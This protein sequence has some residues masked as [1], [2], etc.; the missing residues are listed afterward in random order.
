[1]IHQSLL[2]RFLQDAPEHF[3]PE[4]LEAAM[5]THVRGSGRAEEADEGAAEPSLQ[6]TMTKE[7]FDLSSSIWLETPG[8]GEHADAVEKR[9]RLEGLQG[10]RCPER[11]LQAAQAS[12]S[13]AATLAASRSH[14]RL[15]GVEKQ[16]QVRERQAVTADLLLNWLHGDRL[17]SQMNAKQHELLGLVVDRILIEHGLAQAEDTALRRSDPLVWLMHGGPGTGKTHVLPFLREL[18]GM[19]DY[20]Q[21]IEYE[22][23]AFQAV[24]A[25]DVAGKT[26]H[27]ACGLS[28]GSYSLDREASRETA[29]RMSC[30][31]WLIID[32]ISMV[33]ARLLAQVEQ[34]MRAVMPAA[35]PWKL[36]SH[37][38]AR[39]FAG[40]N[41]LLLGDFHQLKPPEGGFLADVPVCLKQGEGGQA[42]DLLL[43]HGKHLLWGGPTQGVT[44]LTERQRCKDAWWNQVVDEFRAWHL[45]ETNWKYLHG[46][47]VE[48]C[49]LSPEERASR[50]RV[51]LSTDDPRL[52]E[53]KFVEAPVIVANNDSKY[54]INKDRAKAYA[55]AA[56]TPLRFSVALDLASSEALQAEECDKSAKVRWLQYHDRD[57][58]DLCGVLPLAVGMPVALTQHIDR[59]EDKLLLRG[60]VGRVH[61]WHWPEN[62]QQPKVVSLGLDLCVGSWLARGLRFV[63]TRTL[64]YCMRSAVDDCKRP[65][66]G[67]SSSMMSPGNWMV[68]PSRGCIPC[69]SRSAPGSWTRRERSPC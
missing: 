20:L 49:T 23:A 62:D 32:E 45:S 26:L 34:R 67:T 64:N 61:S 39:P 27:S 31:R 5:A 15:G 52:A 24:N 16:P 8:S 69:S 29:K 7:M 22:V 9:R 42:A 50:R 13:Q 6:H 21:G 11:I 53:K 43:E 17:R 4:D 65:S 48:G 51:L 38:Q 41:V 14:L 25:A 66:L 58:A 68:R 55:R 1:M 40:V 18:F 63:N 10:V 19:L 12:R 60:R 47:P 59:S 57:T 56:G 3:S 35:N 37:G 44:E 46:Q 33:N 28:V 2:N 30:W 54:Q 36:D